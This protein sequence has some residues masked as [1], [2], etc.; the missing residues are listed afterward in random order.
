MIH[1]I[2]FAKLGGL[3]PAVVQDAGTGQVL[4]VGFMNKEAI[5]KTIEEKRVTFW[6]RSRKRLWQKGETSGNTLTVESIDM[7]CDRD[8]LLISATPSGP[9]CHTGEFSCFGENAVLRRSTIED[10]ERIIAKRKN[11][12]PEGSYTSRLVEKGT[13]YVAQKIGEEAVEVIVASLSNDKKAVHQEGADLM[14]HLLVLLAMQDSSF[15]DILEV[16]RAR[17]SK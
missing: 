17:M 15:N 14:Y 5:E 6:S 7:D 8:A 9:V 16:L 12:K 4:M 10:L 3:V 2:D 13:P 1:E 11:A